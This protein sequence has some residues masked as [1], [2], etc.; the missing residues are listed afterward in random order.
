MSEVTVA[1]GS[2]ATAT[3]GAQQLLNG[4]A[5]L[6]EELAQRLVPQVHRMGKLVARFFARRCDASSHTIW[7]S[8]SRAC[9]RRSAG[10]GRS[11]LQAVGHGLETQDGLDLRVILKSSLCD[12]WRT[13]WLATYTPVD[14]VT[15]GIMPR[16]THTI[17]GN[18]AL[19]A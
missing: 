2:V 16:R 3:G 7:S 1:T 18:C 8:S 5:G 17:R 11:T 10:S 15:A 19:P 14:T 6:P 9:C 13:R 12:T 4:L